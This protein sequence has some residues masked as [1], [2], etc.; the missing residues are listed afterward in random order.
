MFDKEVEFNGKHAT[1]IRFL[2]DSIGL[3]KTFREA[4]VVCTVVGFINGRKSSK[5]SSE[6]VQPASILPSELAKQRS[7]LMFVYRLIMLLEGP[8]DMD[9]KERQD[10][11]FRYDAEGDVNAVK[12]SQNMECFNAYA[13]GGLEIIYEEFK[14]CTNQKDT[15]NKL[16]E[17]LL[18]FFEDNSLIIDD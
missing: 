1:Y 10:R 18:K 13:M 12:L 2:R 3:F 16:H 15:V 9:I 17:Y 14:D 11:A 5:D 6:K 7:N 4:Y 8:E